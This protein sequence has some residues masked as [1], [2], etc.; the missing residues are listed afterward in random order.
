MGK[1]QK[2]RIIPLGKQLMEYLWRYISSYRPK[3][4]MLK[5]DRVFLTE[6]GQPLRK[7]RV[8]FI[9]KRY[10][11]KAG[12]LGVRRSPHTFHHTA[13]VNFLRNGGDVFTLQRMLGRSSL[14]MTRRYCQVVD[15]DIKRAHIT[16]S[17][18]DNLGISSPHHAAPKNRQKKK[19]R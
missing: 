3:P 4:P 1:G 16:A 8:E 18:V 12:I 7:N 11:L 9:I 13:A 6:K 14:E 10:G 17:P 2:Q 15:V 5:D 19:R